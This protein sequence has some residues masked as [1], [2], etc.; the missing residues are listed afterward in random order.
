LKTSWFGWVGMCT[1]P[2]ECP[3]I[4]SDDIHFKCVDV[5]WTVMNSI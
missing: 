4:W 2:L 5:I 3:I 1:R